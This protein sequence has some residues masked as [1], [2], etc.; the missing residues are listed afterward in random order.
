LSIT[1]FFTFGSALGNVGKP[2]ELPRLDFPTSHG[3]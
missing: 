1:C 3:D 2:W